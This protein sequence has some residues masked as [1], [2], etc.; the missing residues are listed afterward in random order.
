VKPKSASTRLWVILAREAPVGVIFR[1]G[2]SKQV[3]MIKWNLKDDT[4][5]EGQWFKG[6]IYE[7]RSDLSP[8]GRLLIYFA[9]NYKEPLNTWTAISK[10][11]FFT[12]LALWPKG[13]AWNG[14]GYFVGPWDIHL[15]HPVRSSLPHVDFAQGARRF[16]ISSLASHRGEDPLVRDATRHRAGWKFVSKGK[17]KKYG[18]AKAL[19]TT[20]KAHPSLPL[21]LAMEIHGIGQ[22]SGP[23]YVTRYCVFP[24]SDLPSNDLGFA[25]W[26]EWDAGGDLLFARS[27]CI[28][29]Q[30][31][32]RGAWHPAKLLADF[33]GNK[34]RNLPPP[35]W[36]MEFLK[37]DL[38]LKVPTNRRRSSRRR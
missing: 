29:R 17:W 32:A 9:A 12:A 11:P 20:V 18:E 25:D 19:E 38:T 37:D 4:F 26:A 10:P 13:D 7:R 22:V 34:F 27:G 36:A 35:A 30:R 1:R 21:T 2:P 14:G 33:N 3:Q 8:N 24:D 15:D 16:H 23:W 6:R 28:Y 5:E 31:F